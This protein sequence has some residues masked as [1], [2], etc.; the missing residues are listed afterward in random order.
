MMRRWLAFVLVWM[1]FTGGAMAQPGHYQ[2]NT[3]KYQVTDIERAACQNDAVELCSTSFPDEEA[4]LACMKS[5][6]LKLTP[7]CRTTFEAGL[8]RRHIPF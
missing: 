7:T 6:R 5:S 1:D 4:L 8:R 3:N 2:V